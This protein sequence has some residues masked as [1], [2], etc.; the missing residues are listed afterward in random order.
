MIVAK[1]EEFIRN[2]ILITYSSRLR[3]ELDIFI[4]NNGRPEA[5]R[6]SNDDLIM[7]LAIGCWVRD[8]AIIENQT[9]SAYKKAMLGAI[10]KSNS[11][12]DTTIP[13]MLGRSKLRDI[14][15][16]RSEAEKQGA[17]MIH[18]SLK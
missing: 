11:V 9:D 3:S 13:G 8:T 14:D 2:K 15:I 10:M 5:M 6:T 12:L 7:A 4:W 18:E 1:F 17:V 16:K